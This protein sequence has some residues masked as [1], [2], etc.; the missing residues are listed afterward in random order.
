MTTRY[1]DNALRDY[2]TRATKGKKERRTS[3]AKKADSLADETIHSAL[4]LS[5]QRILRE[6]PPQDGAKSRDFSVY[7]GACARLR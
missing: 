3:K 7:T 1:I 4:R 5:L 2:E 6:S